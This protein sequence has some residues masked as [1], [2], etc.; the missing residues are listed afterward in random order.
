VR[1]KDTDKTAMFSYISPEAR[2]PRD[3]PLRAI[4]LMVQCGDQGY[5]AELLPDIL[6][7]RAPFYSAGPPDHLMRAFLLHAVPHPQRATVDGAV[8]LQLAVP[9]V[10]RTLIEAWASHKTFKPKHDDGSPPASGTGRSPEVDFR[11][12]KR[13][14]ETH[15]STTHPDARF[16]KK[17][18]GSGAKPGY[19]GNVMSENHNGLSI[20]ARVTRATARPSGRRRW[21]GEPRARSQASDLGRRQGI[22]YGGLR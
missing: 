10:C 6:A 18:V 12:S 22:R 15:A 13:K 16:Y 14:K 7:F 8:G 11:G 1:S 9:L 4:R 20:A 2:A 21:G 3:H 17:S 19:P 5:L